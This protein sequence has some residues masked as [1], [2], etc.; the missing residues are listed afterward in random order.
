MLIN[1]LFLT[2]VLI[3]A[4]FV[5]AAPSYAA[6][7]MEYYTY[8][9]FD[10][11]VSAFQKAA[12][13]FS[14]NNFMK[15]M[16]VVITLGIFFAASSS[17]LSAL[18]GM[19]TGGFSWALPVGIGVTL[20]LATI[21]PKGTL[22]IYDPVKNR[23]QAVGSIP[24][25]IVLLAG[26]T[27]LIERAMVDV[28][29]TSA[30]PMGYQ[31]QAGGI[32]FDFLN[33]LHSGG[34]TMADQYIQSSLQ[35]YTEDCLFFELMRP[36]TTLS[37]NTISNNV[38]L[39]A[40]YEMAKNPAVFTVYSKD[41]DLWREGI[42]MSCDAAF[43]VLSA[44]VQSPAQYTN[45]TKSKCAEMGYD[46]TN[47]L[48][49]TQCKDMISNLG[50]WV[51]GTAWS[52][53]FLFSQA[54]LASA[55]YRA[56][57]QSSPDT[58]MALMM[59]RNTGT[60]ML[61]TGAMANT[62]IPIIRGILISVAVVITPFLVIFLPT[63]LFGKALG[64]ISG[65]FV[66]TMSW[67]I[68]DAALHGLAMD[69]AYKAMED[70]RQN[71]LGTMAISAFGTSSLKALA[72]F[73]S[74]RWA[75]LMLSTVITGMMIKFGG[76]ALAMMAGSLTSPVQGAAAKAGMDTQ[77]PEGRAH[78]IDAMPSA[79]SA[80]LYAGKYSFD[81]M[82]EAITNKRALDTGSGI[83]LGNQDNAFGAGKWN[84]RNMVEQTKVE[85]EAFS[86]PDK[87]AA[88]GIAP[89]IGRIEAAGGLDNLIELT[90]TTGKS[91]I[92]AVLEGAKTRL[93]A[94]GKPETPK[95]ILQAIVDYKKDQAK[96]EAPVVLAKA[97]IVDSIGPSEVT[98]ATIT[99]ETMAIGDAE[100]F[101]ELGTWSG[102]DMTTPEGQKQY[103]HDKFLASKIKTSTPI[104][105]PTNANET[106]KKSGI[107]G[108]KF[109]KG[110]AVSDLKKVDGNPVAFSVVSEDKKT[111]TTLHDGK[112]TRA[113]SGEFQRGDYNIAGS[114]I[115]TSD[116]TGKL[117]NTKYAGVVTD[118][119]TG[120]KYEGSFMEDKKGL[121]HV[122][123]HGGTTA[124]KHKEKFKKEDNRDKVT[125]GGKEID[126]YDSKTG[127]RLKGVDGNG[128][129]VGDEISG[130]F[131]DKVVREKA[132]YE[133]N[134]KRGT[135]SYENIPGL[136]GMAT[137]LNTA[138]G[139]SFA[140]PPDKF[141]KLN[142]VTTG[143]AVH[144]T[145][146]FTPDGKMVEGRKSSVTY[147]E[148]ELEVGGKTFM[149]KIFTE[150]RTGKQLAIEAKSGEVYKA[151][152]GEQAWELQ[153]QMLIKG[154]IIPSSVMGAA[155]KAGFSKEAQVDAGYYV[156]IGQKG[157]KEVLDIFPKW[158]GST[159]KT[160]DSQAKGP[161]VEIDPTKP[162]S[163]PKAQD[164]YQKKYMKY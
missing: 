118:T 60:S 63:P 136:G 78:L 57:I 111:T 30:D 93:K 109:Q 19:K 89:L 14:D 22:N 1:A 140:I 67:G 26:T 10:Q 143:G 106:L 119:T 108:F 79:A 144:V 95:N 148:G 87:K 77:T 43:T 32:G 75:G 25:G 21:V 123:A 147:T 8:N 27:N 160:Q 18:K 115:T 7:E 94:K 55:Y 71:G 65:L 5:T 112:I 158:K 124:I 134:G 42:T 59:S 85:K 66:W 82:T 142:M 91:E 120:E 155:E 56:V 156:G 29:S 51:E 31:N 52:T 150:S 53:T 9:S 33:N 113:E 28:V 58:A 153:T 90:K 154:D 34:I 152:V 24:E 17:M 76:H 116:A 162:Y 37:V 81:E 135:L 117:L 104:K 121:V 97:K 3:S 74:V 151:T 64:I 38:D 141:D 48:E 35:R 2:V 45:F 39:L 101:K 128:G 159:V 40:L 110:D 72:M 80:H 107:T 23:F 137:F 88:L 138:D 103:A 68:I 54:A 146:K 49:Y 61:A 130:V 50:T 163:N 157:V 145:G 96:S 41:D 73:G 70:I 125:V 122:D 98:D 47:A 86:T 99:K 114:K 127:E 62:W 84:S 16:F 129:F 20:F 149:A 11:V 161:H 105:D 36:N 139:E 44:D 100:G 132:V 126:S 12:L 133:Y 69:Y 46:P 6:L 13:M 164:Y 15:L 131:K 4:V 102:Y 92:A 83:G